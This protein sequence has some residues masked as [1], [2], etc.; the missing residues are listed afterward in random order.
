ML[1]WNF[2]ISPKFFK[3]SFI[4][5]Q[6]ILKNIKKLL[7]KLSCINHI[8]FWSITF[9]HYFINL[10][11]FYFF[12]FGFFSFFPINTPVGLFIG[13]YKTRRDVAARITIVFV[14]AKHSRVRNIVTAA[15]T[16][17]PRVTR[18]NEASAITIPVFCFC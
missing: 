5:Y 4:F 7:Q 9:Y 3:K 14:E 1:Y 6:K 17:E 18:T 8:C 13:N 12:H 15:T 16:S 10:L 2:F 11:N